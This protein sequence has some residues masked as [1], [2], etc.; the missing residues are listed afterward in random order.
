MML[1]NLVLTSIHRRR[2]DSARIQASELVS[3]VQAQ[4]VS[5]V[6]LADLPPSPPSKTR[7]LV[8][9]STPHCLTYGFWSGAGDRRLADESTQPLRDAGAALVATTLAETRTY[10]GGLA[11]IARI[12]APGAR[13]SV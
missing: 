3:L 9:R 4:G 13:A 12:P 11:E 10:L 6:C 8:K 5:M 1:A 2:D 7:Y